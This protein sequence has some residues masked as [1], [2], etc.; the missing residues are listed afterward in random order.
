MAEDRRATSFGTASAIAAFLIWGI[1]PLYWRWLGAVPPLEL[2]AHRVFWSA[3]ILLCMVVLLQRRQLRAALRDRRALVAA[4][5]A[6]VL[7]GLNWFVY[8]WSI[9]V[10]RL[11]EAS[12]GYYINPLVSVLLGVV[13]LRERLT[14]AQMVA[15]SLAIAGVLVLTFSY[16]QFPWV[17]LALAFSFGIYGL[18]KKVG[19]LSNLV[20]LLVEMALTAPAAAAYL[21]IIQ[22]AGTA[23]FVRS[24]AL[25]SVLLAGAG[26]V[27]VAPLWLFGASARRIPLSSVG[28]F[29]YLAPT[30]MLLIG[31]LIFREPFTRAHGVAF[32]LI[33]VALG[34]Y[35]VSLV[36]RREAR[37]QAGS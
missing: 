23:A 17:S 30:T 7:L 9:S 35:S 12:L 19:R 36:R 29:Q 15:L 11:V 2:L 20:S 14:R 4:M 26:I 6:G 5:L 37:R 8:I 24:G 21:G 18:V 1:L 32:A 13:F 28:F 27:T 22:R 34:I 10:D 3:A 25:T 31:T 16:G 33:W